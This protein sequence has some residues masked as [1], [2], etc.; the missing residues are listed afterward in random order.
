M[1]WRLQPPLAHGARPMTHG[2]TLAQ[3]F[4]GSTTY[5]VVMGAALL[6]VI[7]LFVIMKKRQG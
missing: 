1:K 5:Y 7:A 6:V 3:S 4:V 2:L